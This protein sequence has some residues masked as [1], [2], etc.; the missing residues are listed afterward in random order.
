MDF[1]LKLLK[2]EF[3]AIKAQL[4]EHDEQINKI[5]SLMQSAAAKRP[6]NS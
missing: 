5:L 2:P 4:A 1:Y 3:D 6:L